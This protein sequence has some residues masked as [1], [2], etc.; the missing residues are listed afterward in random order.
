MNN[1]CVAHRGW[2]GIAPENTISAI[3][4]ALNHP[5]ITM[6]ELDVQLSLDG[7]PV[8][9][10]DFTL[11]RTT[12]GDGF[13]GSKTCKEL[14]QLDAGKWFDL[15]FEGEQIPTLEEVF[16]LVMGKK[17]LNIEIK[18]PGLAYEG[19]EQAV[20]NLVRKYGMENQVWITSFN[21]ESIREM[22]K[23]GSDLKHGPIIYGLPIMLDNILEETCANVLSMNYFYLTKPMVTPLLDRGIDIIAWTIDDPQW[24][25]QTAS[26]DERIAICTNHPDR[27]FAIW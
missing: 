5:D 25:A 12:D 21:H 17:R 19:I 23:I 18:R 8:V 16:Q 4:L 7:I 20:V 27:W 1:S 14:K 15:R 26:I 2:S 3:Q 10:H 22:A 6:I 11:E 13:V 24:M 9:I